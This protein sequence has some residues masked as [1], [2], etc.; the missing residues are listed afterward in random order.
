MFKIGSKSNMVS[1]VV[2]AVWDAELL[3]DEYG[4]CLGGFQMAVQPEDRSQFTVE[5]ISNMANNVSNS[6]C[7]V[8]SVELLS[9][10]IA[11]QVMALLLF[12]NACSS[13]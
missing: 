13:R 5:T 10:A 8:I 3:C 12:L 1:F 11:R 4:S 2:L 7:C 6:I 9:M